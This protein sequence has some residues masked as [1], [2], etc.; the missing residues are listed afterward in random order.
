MNK[1]ELKI[2]LFIGEALSKDPLINL[3]KTHQIQDRKVIN[4][5]FHELP[6][7]KSSKDG[8][9]KDKHYSIL[10]KVFDNNLNNIIN[11]LNEA[12]YLDEV[13]KTRILIDAGNTCKYIISKLEEYNINP[14][15]IS[16][17]LMSERLLK[18]Y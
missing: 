4:Y 2:K 8:S 12:T 11:F 14:M 5:L 17:E 18:M 10:L 15:R 16:Q 7:D 13:F 9:I 3:I 1:I 6:I